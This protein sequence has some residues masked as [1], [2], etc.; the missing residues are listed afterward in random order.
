MAN[1][2]HTSIKF[3]LESFKSDIPFLDTR[4]KIGTDNKISTS[5]FCK[6]TDKHTYLKYFSNHPL[7]IKNSTVFSQLLRYR[8]ICS[9][10]A[11]FDNQFTDLV[12]H[13]LKQ[14]YPLKLLKR[15]WNR[16]R[17]IPRP[18]LLVDK[19]TD[20]SDRIPLVIT[21]NKGL[22]FVLKNI[23]RDWNF[24]KSDKDLKLIFNSPMTVAR[25]Q[26]PPP[27]PIY[28]VCS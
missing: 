22:D 26:P 10:V 14:G 12:G 8:R 24:L 15:T 9:N 11:I 3:T 17:D 1:N 2:F 25:R 5:V 4:V 7:H 13:F 6:P 28:V 18:T 16:V 27:P 21:Q 19:P 23:K 20:K